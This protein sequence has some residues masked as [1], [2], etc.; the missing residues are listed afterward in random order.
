MPTLNYQGGVMAYSK[1]AY[2]RN[3]D[4][5][6]KRQARYISKQQAA[7]P[8]E[9][10]RKKREATRKHRREK[11]LKVKL[12]LQGLLGGK[13]QSC[14]I[15]DHR[16]LDFDHIDPMTKEMLIS[17]SYNKPLRVLEAEISKCRLLCANCHR[18]ATWESGGFDSWKRRNYRN[19]NRTVWRGSFGPF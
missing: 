9:W 2:Q 13:C 17:Q 10:K 5:H 15:A 18:V 12:H 11:L 16:V 6:Q 4:A 7:D 19:K 14:G 8:E 3:K 1:E